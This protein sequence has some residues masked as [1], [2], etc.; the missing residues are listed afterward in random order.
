MTLH[1]CNRHSYKRFLSFKDD[2]LS[3]KKRF[4]VSCLFC[5]SITECMVF[6]RS[7]CVVVPLSIYFWM[8][9]LILCSTAYG[10]DT[11]LKRLRFRLLLILLSTPIV[12][13]NQNSRQKLK[14]FLNF[15][16]WEL[17][18]STL[19]IKTVCSKNAIGKV[20]RLHLMRF[21][22]WFVVTLFYL[23]KNKF[24]YTKKV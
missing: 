2:I 9:L 4:S 13:M 11:R 18:N 19:C 14:L 22:Q 7:L 10:R 12:W 3:H 6:L 1:I 20:Q 17:H 23:T 21:P 5:H 15:P 8:F 24:F 16:S